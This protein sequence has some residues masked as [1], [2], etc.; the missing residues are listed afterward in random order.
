MLPCGS[1]LQ[2]CSAPK[3]HK[4]LLAAPDTK[5]FALRRCSQGTAANAASRRDACGAT[6]DFSLC[7]LACTPRHNSKL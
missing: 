1:Q 7:L 2:L 4:N 3:C 6:V 5:V